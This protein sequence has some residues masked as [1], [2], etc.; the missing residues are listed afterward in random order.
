MHY[1][2]KMENIL[3]LF[4]IATFIFGI[5]SLT[6]FLFTTFKTFNKLFI[7]IL[8]FYLN[9]T[10]LIF[11]MVI[12]NY[13]IINLNEYYY[14]FKSLIQYLR[15]LFDY[16]THLS[17]MLLIHYLFSKNYRK[18][19]NFFII[20]VL[21]FS[22]IVEFLSIIGINL[23]LALYDKLN[24][25]HFLANIVS[26]LLLIYLLIIILIKYKS[27]K[28]N[29]YKNLLRNLFITTLI[30]LPGIVFDKFNIKYHAVFSPLM[31]CIIS[32]LLLRFILKFYNKN[33][34]LS[35]VE[36]EN[37]NNNLLN[38]YDITKR[39]KEIIMLILKGY[40]NRKIADSIFVSINTVKT[41]VYN[42]Y[43]KLKIN[44]RYELMH[45]VKNS[46]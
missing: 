24:E 42:I 11:F 9:F 36:I 26:S 25:E 28:K 31:Y 38:E 15:L 17:G 40:N 32:T 13:L 19:A 39:E 4:Y 34:H 37:I 44:N 12:K 10:L 18:K 29:E 6:T 33:Y 8:F 30:F 3:F 46:Y 20:P 35:N 2:E 14:Q 23:Y 16:L 22:Y 1:F 43:N 41:H 21:T 45:F 27:I 7:H 5:S